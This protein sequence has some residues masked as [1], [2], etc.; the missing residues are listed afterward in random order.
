ML[1]SKKKRWGQKRAPAEKVDS[2]SLSLTAG[3][4]A[5][6]YKEAVERIW[7]TA[8]NFS[9][10][11]WGA[12][13]AAMLVSVPNDFWRIYKVARGSS[14]GDPLQ[15]NIHGW[16]A[17]KGIIP[18]SPRP[19]LEIFGM[20][21]VSPD[22]LSGKQIW[23]CEWRLPTAWEKRVTGLPTTRKSA[24]HRCVIFIYLFLWLCH[25]NLSHCLGK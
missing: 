8:S 19:R 12:G 21:G 9:V 6:P 23:Y 20:F 2:I 24:S 16:N 11:L 25:F 3:Q 15:K 14:A 18:V 10:M 5:N 22:C 7:L 17:K 1:G 13:T 4:R